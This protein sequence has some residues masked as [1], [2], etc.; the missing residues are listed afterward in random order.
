M[1]TLIDGRK[2]GNDLQKNIFNNINESLSIEQY[3]PRKNNIA[4]TII[5]K[6]YFNPSGVLERFRVLFITILYASGQFII[7]D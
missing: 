2:S 7:D 3:G 4:K 1:T 5:Q 6:E